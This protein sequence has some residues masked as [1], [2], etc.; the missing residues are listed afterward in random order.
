MFSKVKISGNANSSLNLVQR[1]F[2][3]VRCRAPPC[4][5]EIYLSRTKTCY[6]LPLRSTRVLTSSKTQGQ[7]V[8]TT[9]SREH[10][11]KPL[12]WLLLALL[13]TLSLQGRGC[14]HDWKPI[15]YIC[16][17]LW[18]YFSWEELS[19]MLER[20]KRIS[21]RCFIGEKVRF[22]LENNRTKST[23]RL[24]PVIKTTSVQRSSEL[25]I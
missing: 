20:G 11:E 22:L 14:S 15:G 1:K 25:F 3:E 18:L 6:E 12:F 9:E 4:L 19:K 8:G 16:S 2:Y 23:E 17:T 24:I 13:T 5:F 21:H 7:S 10:R